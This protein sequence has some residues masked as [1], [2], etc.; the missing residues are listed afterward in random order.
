MI[1]TLLEPT[2]INI[3]GIEP[4]DI[5]VHN[6]KLYSRVLQHGALGLGEAYIENWWDCSQLDRLFEK[7]LGAHLENKVS[8]SF[9]YKIKI[10]LSK[11]I[12]F[13]SFS[14]AKI[15][16]KK[17]YDLGNELFKAMLDKRMIYSCG[18][19]K[20]TH[21]LEEAQTAK[22][23]LICK[24]LKLQKGQRILDIGCGWGGFARFAAENYGVSVVGITISKEQSEYAKEY[25]KDL[26]IEIRLQDY[27]ELTDRFDHIVSVGMFEHVGHLNYRHYMEIVNRALKEDGLFL[28]HTIG[29]NYTSL[30]ANEWIVKY[31]FPN[32]I[33]PSIAQIGKA[34]EHKFVMEDWHNFG[35]YYDLTLM[36]WH[37][38]FL[39]HWDNLKKI[40]DDRFFRIWSYYLLSCAGSFR[41]RSIQ[42]WQIVLSKKGIPGGYITSR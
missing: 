6:E 32:G 19:F 15:V 14:R 8:V 38:N 39:A 11:M 22:L 41:V 24:K 42:L 30:L 21:S 17:H 3:N 10:A 29:G 7:I 1:E 5:Q 4:W 34:I 13:Q 37:K 25:C 12:N 28:L 20:D 26:P 31:I 18:Y 27:R 36:N 23:D 40:Y 33:T 16:A 9:S 2:G 35:S